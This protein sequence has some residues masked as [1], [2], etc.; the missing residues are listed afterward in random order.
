MENINEKETAVDLDEN[1]A[2]LTEDEA[3]SEESEAAALAEESKREKDTEEDEKK[4]SKDKVIWLIAVFLLILIFLTAIMLFANLIRFAGEKEDPPRVEIDISIYA[5]LPYGYGGHGTAGTTAPVQ[6][7]APIQTTSPVQTTAPIQTT[8]SSQTTSAN[9]PKPY[10]PPVNTSDPKLEV[11]DGT[12]WSGEALVDIFRASYE[13]DNGDITVKSADGTHVIAPG[14]A[15]SY[16][17]DVKNMGDVGV[18]YTLQVSAVLT[19]KAGDETFEIPLEAR[20]Y[21]RNGKYLLG[22]AADYAAMSDLDGLKESGQLSVGKYI[23]Y[24]LDWQWPINGNDELDTL[25]GNLAAKGEEISVSIRL[26]VDA[27]ANR[28]A[29]GGVAIGK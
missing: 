29:Y 12:I 18:N 19:T 10:Y 25:L 5:G 15:N 27:E 11:N 26:Q 22:T 2:A 6:T 8:A 23:R 4:S 7:T 3:V 9:T 17:F 13:N 20:F 16:Y 1:T 21:D 24:V 28:N 14:T